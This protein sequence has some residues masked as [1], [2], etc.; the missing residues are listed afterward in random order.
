MRIMIDARMGHT[1]VGMGVYVRGL[2]RSLSKIDKENEY[3]VILNKGKKDNFIP[4]QDN[5]HKIYT[6]VTY[7]NYLKRDLWEQIYLPI[8]LNR[9]NIDVYHGPNYILPLFSNKKMILTIYDTTISFSNYGWYKPVSRYRVQKLLSLSAKK[10]DKIITGSEHSKKDIISI[11]GIPEEKIKVIYIGVDEEYKVIKDQ[12]KLNLVK[13]KY[14]LNK[15]FILHVGSL[16]PRKNISR[17]IEAYNKLPLELSKEYQLVL[18]GGKGWR[19]NEI[20]AKIEKLGLN[21]KVLF[22]GFVEDDDLHLLMNAASLLVFPS[23]Y[24]GFGI[25]PLEAMA[26]GIPVVAS[27]TSSIPEVVGDAALLFDPYNVEEMSVAIYKALTDEQ[28]RN[29]LVKRG[30]ERVK[31]FSWKK[32]AQETL[33]VYNE[34]YNSI[35]D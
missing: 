13:A 34:I 23:L 24:E 14:G 11:L 25:P 8:L 1:R 3:F 33:A 7:S 9:Y 31:Y 6:G 12:S 17:L 18:V 20:F 32:T 28:L 30:F 5:F 2:L 4:L 10:A 19:S 22:T 26:C 15:K 29:D 35:G 16:N 27:N 21:D